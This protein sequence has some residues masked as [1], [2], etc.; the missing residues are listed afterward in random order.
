MG[1]LKVRPS[2]R[3][4]AAAQDDV[5]LW[6]P[7]SYVML[8]RAHRARVEARTPQSN[9]YPSTLIAGSSMGITGASWSR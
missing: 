8:S 5:V 4:F 1:L 2:T 6:A 9:P 7:E 3:R